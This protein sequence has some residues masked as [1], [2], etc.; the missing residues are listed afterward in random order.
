[1]SEAQFQETVVTDPRL[2]PHLSGIQPAWLWSS[3]GTKIL[4]TNATGAAA[5]GLSGRASLEQALGPADPHRRQIAQLANHLPSSGATRLERMRGFGASLGHLATCSCARLALADGTSA[6]LVASLVSSAR[7]LSLA[8]RLQFL[9]D[10][11]DKP[12]AAFSPEGA[13]LA[14]NHAARNHLGDVDLAA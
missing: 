9:L 14:A 2:A 1:M 13:L 5:L 3:D 12:A 4:W 8:D 10:R 7:P 11:I 6:I